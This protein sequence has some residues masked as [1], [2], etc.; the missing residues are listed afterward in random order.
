MAKSAKSGFTIKLSLDSKEYRDNLK[1]ARQLLDKTFSGTWQ[2]LS[3]RA[4]KI[5]KTIA[6]L[7]SVLTIVSVRLLPNLRSRKYHLKE[8]LAV[9]KRPRKKSDPC[10]ILPLELLLLSISFWNMKRGF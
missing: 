5:T 1:H 3:R 4:E 6:G 10:G 8:Y 2:Y 9:P 7:G